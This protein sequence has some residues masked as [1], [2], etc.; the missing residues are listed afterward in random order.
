[1]SQ[2]I[3]ESTL[4]AIWGMLLAMLGLSLALGYL[5]NVVL[6]TV[7]IFLV[8]TLKACLVANYY[9][10]LKWEP[11][12]ILW[13]LLTGVIFMIILFAALVPDIIYVYG[14]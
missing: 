4:I 1:M 13:I 14:K 6:A 2:R 9:M 3:S 11:K 5:G 7:L 12:Y 8:A 10:G